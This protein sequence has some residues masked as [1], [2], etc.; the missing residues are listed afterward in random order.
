MEYQLT[1]YTGGLVEVLTATKNESKTSSKSD[2]YFWYQ[3]IQ[4][5]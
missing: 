4:E 1:P 5:A 3:G 2:E